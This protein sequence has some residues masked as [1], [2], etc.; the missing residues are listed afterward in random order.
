M[1]VFDDHNI[2]VSCLSHQ[3]SLSLIADIR[4]LVT[5]EG[6]YCKSLLIHFLVIAIS[7]ATQVALYLRIEELGL[8]ER[9]GGEGR[10]GE[11]RGGEGRGG[12]GRGG[13]GRGGRGM[14][15]QL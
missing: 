2:I 1:Q 14:E 3:H 13:E 10:G 7:V 9:R 11:G 12:E 8:G 4:V 15:L 5:D 6:V